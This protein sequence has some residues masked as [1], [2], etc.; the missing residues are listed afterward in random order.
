MSKQGLLPMLGSRI[1]GVSFGV[2]SL[3]FNFATAADKVCTTRDFSQYIAN[4]EWHHG[5]PQCNAIYRTH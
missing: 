4:M 3:K 5:V 1:V 2:P